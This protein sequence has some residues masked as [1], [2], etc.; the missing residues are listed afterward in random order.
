MF[1]LPLATFCLF[2]RTRAFSQE[3]VDA[4]F[5]FINTIFRQLRIRAEFL[6]KSFHQAVRMQ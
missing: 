1:Y 4:F 5:A 2:L 6:V 3:S